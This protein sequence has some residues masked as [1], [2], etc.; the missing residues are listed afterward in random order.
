[1][2]VNTKTVWMDITPDVATQ[3][4]MLNTRN[5]VF[6]KACVEKY[7]RDMADG[8]WKITHQGIGISKTNVLLDG[9]QR[10]MA[11]VKSG[12]TISMFVTTGL[13]DDAQLVM[14]TGRKRNAAQNL[15]LRGIENPKT[16]VTF[17]NMMKA[18]ITGAINA[19][20]TESEHLRIYDEIQVDW[21][22]ACNN[23]YHKDTRVATVGG[24]I[25]FA[26]PKSR[27][28]VSTF[29]DSFMSGVGLEA[30][31]PILS[32]KTIAGRSLGYTHR[33]E[34]ALRLLRCLEAHV[35][36][37]TPMPKKIHVNESAVDFFYTDKAYPVGS[38]LWETGAS[39][40]ELKAKEA[41]QEAATQAL[42]HGVKEEVPA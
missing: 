10:L 9:Q 17:V 41:E 38:L 33:R 24:V 4:L 13:E 2:P 23:L 42:A 8:N 30:G 32:A 26:Y 19:T 20:F 25:F 31:S 29:V 35:R 40:R 6:D 7:A 14:D 3:F 36:G 28:K 22:W 39:R 37:Q 18:I 12:V 27:E 21:R 15:G 5:R 34:E 1:M 16:F 11:I